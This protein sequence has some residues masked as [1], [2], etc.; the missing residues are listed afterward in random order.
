MRRFP[1]GRNVWQIVVL[2]LLFPLSRYNY[3]LFHSL[4]ELFSIIIASGIFVIA[5]NGR[6]H[7]RN[8]YLLFI[9]IAFLFVAGVDLLHTL[10]FPG[11][12]IFIDLDK[13][14]LSIQL[15]LTARFLEACTLLT[16]PWFIVH[17]LR[18]GRVFTLYGTAAGVVCWSIFLARN[19]PV[20]FI[21]G[22]GLTPFKI[23][24]EYVIIAILLGAFTL[25]ARLR[26]QLDARVRQLLLGSILFTIAS[27]FCF[28]LYV[29]H[30]GLAN[31]FGHIFKIVSFA[32]IYRAIIATAVERPYAL[33]FREIK[34][35]EEA[36]LAA[37]RAAKMGSWVWQEGGDKME[38]TAEVFGI[39]GLE[40]GTVTPTIDRLVEAV[41]P[42]DRPALRAAWA[43]TVREGTP[44]R[45]ECRIPERDG[46]FRHLQF[47]GDW[48]RHEDGNRFIAGILRDVSDAVR[49]ARMRDDMEN[50]SR[51]DL[52]SPLGA[53]IMIP[54]LLL[55]EPG[56]L[57]EEQRKLIHEIRRSGL[58]MLDMLNSS[59]NLYK[60]EQGTYQLAPLPF[61]LL[62]ELHDIRNE[63]D[64]VARANNVS[65]QVRLK[66][67]P[68]AADSSFIVTGEK[69]LC[70]TLFTN[71]IGNALE[72][73]PQGET[74]TIDLDETPIAWQIAIHNR[75]VVPDA[76]RP[77]FFEKYVTSGKPGGTGLGTYSAL[78]MV[79]AHGGTIGFTS[80]EPAGTTIT[81]TLPKAH[82]AAPSV[83]PP[84]AG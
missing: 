39:L 77:R 48:D 7:Y 23:V 45:G 27:E 59:L 60:I 12:Q 50:I 46:E 21:P 58:R 22:A 30:Y 67:T 80:R 44:L 36:L 10:A 2:G 79:R 9:G 78:M 25:L 53:I 68:P 51:H 42:E 34:Q 83:P 38:W 65:F 1:T 52:R 70:Y 62:A 69:L 71:L 56:Q 28:T 37:Q 43:R 29:S 84:A 24:S 40:P 16:A 47:E 3:L 54:D 26:H 41:A 82:E 32:L 73:S 74:V 33:L 6:R 57:S 18:S 76:I 20:C 17:R 72:A 66:G 5:W 4:A 13:N 11:M 63:K 81:V 8:D 75:G 35:R 31:F 55:M 64:V 15:W 19:F 49:T 61:D 14:N